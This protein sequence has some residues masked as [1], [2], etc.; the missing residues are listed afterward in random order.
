MYLRAECTAA[1]QPPGVPTPSYYY[2]YYYYSVTA[3][4]AVYIIV[5]LIVMKLLAYIRTQYACTI[6]R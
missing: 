3:M 1:S 2:Y 6:I 4:R 5:V